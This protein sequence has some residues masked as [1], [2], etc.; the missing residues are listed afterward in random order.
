[1]ILSVFVQIVIPQLERDLEKN[2]LVKLRD[3]I[4]DINALVIRQLAKENRDKI[5]GRASLE[6][7]VASSRTRMEP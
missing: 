5:L 7:N 2:C 6:A 4:R 1:M 3:A